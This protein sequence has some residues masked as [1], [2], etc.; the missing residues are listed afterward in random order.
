MTRRLAHHQGRRNGGLL[1]P[2]SPGKLDAM[3]LLVHPLLGSSSG[4]S[5]HSSIARLAAARIA[6]PSTWARV[7]VT[8]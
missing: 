6:D 5:G 4:S 1:V 7:S 8:P 2:G 3:V